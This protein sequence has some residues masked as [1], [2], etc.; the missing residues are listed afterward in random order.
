MSP[1][2]GLNGLVDCKFTRLQ[3]W[4]DFVV[5]RSH[6]KYNGVKGKKIAGVVS[7]AKEFHHLFGLWRIGNSQRLT[8]AHRLFGYPH[9]ILRRCMG[10]QE[11]E[12]ISA[13]AECRP[14]VFFGR[15]F[16]PGSHTGNNPISFYVAPLIVN[17]DHSINVEENSSDA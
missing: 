17:P 8:L 10:Q 3:E 5:G 13:D 1:S 7:V 4:P 12:F 16:E 11:Q 2:F 6:S 15:G 9:S 14:V